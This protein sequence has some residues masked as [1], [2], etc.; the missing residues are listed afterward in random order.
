MQLLAGELTPGSCLLW[1]DVLHGNSS[2]TM[3]GEWWGQSRKGPEHFQQRET[4]FFLGGFRPPGQPQTVARAQDTNTGA[5]CGGNSCHL[6]VSWSDGWCALGKLN[7]GQ[8]EQDFGLLCLSHL[9]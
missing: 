2:R 8:E 6:N 3:S 9:G 1:P 5:E 7:R 4:F